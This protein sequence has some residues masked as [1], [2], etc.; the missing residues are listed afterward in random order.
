MRFIHNHIFVALSTLIKRRSK[1][2]SPVI[3]QL[4]Y[5]MRKNEPNVQLNNL[6]ISYLHMMLNRLFRSK[7]RVHELILYDFLHRYYTSEMAKQKYA[8]RS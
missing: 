1:K 4:T 6:L 3:K 5:K 8:I 2:L 7:N